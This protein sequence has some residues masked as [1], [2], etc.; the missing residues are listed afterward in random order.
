MEFKGLSEGFK[1]VD[2][3]QGIVTGYLAHFGSKDHDGDV[4]EKGAFEKT[5]SE[6][7]P[8]G[9]KFIKY[10]QDHDKHKAV[11]TFLELKE[12]NTGLYY[13]GK[14]GR[15]QA[16]QDYLLMVEDGIINQH[17]VGFKRLRQEVKASVKHI[18]EIRLFEG[19]GLQ[20]WAA[21]GNTPILG[22]KEITDMVA[23][24]DILNKGLKDGSYSDE[25]M[26]EISNQVGI[27]NETLKSLNIDDAASSTSTD[28]TPNILTG[29]VNVLSKNQ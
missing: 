27:I 18:K 24:L 6:N 13:E 20:F 16:G 12:D 2:L 1:D 21:N 14:I 28:V 17:S 5:I 26:I 10:L 23:Y 8:N 29:L 7:G 22:V 15:H 25:A 4:I 9:T 11:G 19:S 3:K